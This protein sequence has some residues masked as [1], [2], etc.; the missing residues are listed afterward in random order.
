MEKAADRAYLSENRASRKTPPG[1][2]VLGE[3]FEFPFQF[4]L[5]RGRSLGNHCNLLSR[6]LLARAATLSVAADQ[7]TSSV[8]ARVRPG[9]HGRQHQNSGS[10]E[11]KDTMK[12]AHRV[13]VRACSFL[14]GHPGAW[15]IG[16]ALVSMASLPGPAWGQSAWPSYPNNSAISVTSGGNVG[17][18]TNVPYDIL[19]VG[20]SFRIANPVFG[21]NGFSFSQDSTG[22]LQVQYKNPTALFANVMT[23]TYAGNVGI[24]TTTPASALDVNGN[25]NA[26]GSL[27]ANGRLLVWSHRRY[28]GR[29]GEGS[30]S[31]LPTR[32]RRILGA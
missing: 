29:V 23:M 1:T 22:N 15:F 14:A 11:R 3:R 24:G 4:R 16:L 21:G 26:S 27:T 10:R 5:R 8:P 25:I 18:G 13:I 30:P 19:H 2:Q 12:R 32:W 31:C 6:M 20:G 28:R 9:P 17:I 7:I